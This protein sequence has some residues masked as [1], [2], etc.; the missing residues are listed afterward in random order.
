MVKALCVVA[1]FA[2]SVQAQQPKIAIVDM[3][4]AFDG[5]YKTKQA[6]AQIKERATDSDKVY[7]GMIEDYKKA[8]EEYRKL[9]DSS[10]DQAVSNEEREKRKKSAEA[11]LLE[12][13]EIE[14]SVKQFEQQARTSI[15]EM[16]KRMR[17]KIVG[18]I[19]EVVNARAKAGGFTLVFD[20]AAVTAYQT[21]IILYSAGENDLTES[22]IKEIN[23]NAPPGSLIS[24]APDTKADSKAG[25]K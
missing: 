24:A 20:L 19:R 16:E 3:K 12:L 21:P 17:D 1:L 23:A 8:N 25:T 9:I 4:K 6:E 14:K 18:E 5:Y 11:K 2:V 15:G 22:I 10:N 13:Q 7:K